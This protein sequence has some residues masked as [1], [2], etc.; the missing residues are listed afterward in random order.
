MEIDRIPNM[1]NLSIENCIDPAPAGS[2]TEFIDFSKIDYSVGEVPL[3]WRSL[4]SFDEACDWYS[5]ECEGHF[6][7][8]LIPYLVKETLP[9]VDKRKKGFNLKFGKFVLSFP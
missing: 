4:R 9:K 7:E 6:V 1:K 5:K 2:K 3:S 8:E